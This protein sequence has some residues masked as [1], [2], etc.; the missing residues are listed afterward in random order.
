MD[1]QPYAAA[2]LVPALAGLLVVVRKRGLR[3][4]RGIGAGI[5]NLEVLER[6]AL[7]PH[8]MIHLVR[9]A[10]RVVLIGTSPSTCQLL[11]GAEGTDKR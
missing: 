9:V 1:I 7:S 10:D 2:I 8:H 6:V 3:L 5:R 4:Q 11:D